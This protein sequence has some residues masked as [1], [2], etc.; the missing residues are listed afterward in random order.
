[1]KFCI[2]LVA[3]CAGCLT[4][5]AEISKKELKEYSRTIEINGVD[6]RTDKSKSKKKSEG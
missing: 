2:L 3:F 1:M 5:S 4:G 6:C